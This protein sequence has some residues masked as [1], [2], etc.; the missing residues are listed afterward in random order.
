MDNSHFRM[1][2]LKLEHLNLVKS[3][4]EEERA[5]LA[6]GHNFCVMY[7]WRGIWHREYC[8]HSTAQAFER[9]YE[10]AG[11]AKKAEIRQLLGVRS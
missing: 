2:E 9:V 7:L 1:F 5:A 8:H 3:F 11:E 4:A 6:R 10:I